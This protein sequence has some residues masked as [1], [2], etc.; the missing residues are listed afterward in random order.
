MNG[1]GFLKHFKQLQEIAEED[2]CLR[3]EPKP[4]KENVA[5][6]YFMNMQQAVPTESEFL[7]WPLQAKALEL[8]YKRIPAVTKAMQPKETSHTEVFT[9]FYVS[10]RKFIRY[11]TN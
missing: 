4:G 2:F 5:L 1:K 3:K 8:D 11:I 6:A 9:D 7:A 10:P